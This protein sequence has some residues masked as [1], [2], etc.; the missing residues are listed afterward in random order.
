[1]SKDIAEKANTSIAVASRFEKLKISGWEEVTSDDLAI[2]FIRI[3]QSGSP[4]V[5]K[6]DGAYLEGAGEGD[7]YNNVQ[8]CYYDGQQGIQV[9][10]A[11][12]NRRYVEWIPRESDGGGYVDSHPLNTPLLQEAEA[13]EK[14]V[15]ILQW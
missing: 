8:N 13:N 11:Y 6:N 2:P 4:Q 7:I 15:L 12:Y 3:L 10:P 1:M 9:I 5:K 14:G